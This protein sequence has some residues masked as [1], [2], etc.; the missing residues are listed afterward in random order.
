MK[1]TDTLFLETTLAS[2][3][4]RLPVRSVV[5]SLKTGNVLLSPGSQLGTEEL[6]KAGVVTDI[7]APSLLHTAGMARAASVHPHAR[8]WGPAGVREKHPEL[9]WNVFGEE[10]WPFD[11]ELFRLEL[12][13]AP[14]LNENAFLHHAS[15]SLHLTDAAFNIRDPKGLMAGFFFRLFGTYRRF[16]VSKLFL[17]YVKDRR[18]FED[19]LRRL[20]ALDFDHVVPSHGEPVENDGK[21]RLLEAFQERGFLR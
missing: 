3:L 15:R 6:I 16:A 2:P 4:F 8:L 12:A 20:M 14:R 18:A 19:A 13:G 1:F 10:R 9:V 5:F 11:D 17:R 7:V 21:A